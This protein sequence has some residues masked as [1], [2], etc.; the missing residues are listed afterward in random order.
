MAR[1]PNLFTTGVASLR[2][3][4]LPA[5]RVPPGRR[6]ISSARIPDRVA[7]SRQAAL[8]TGTF[9]AAALRPAQTT[10]SFALQ[11][12]RT[13]HSASGFVISDLTDSEYHDI[14]RDT[15]ETLHDNLEVL[16]EETDLP[17]FDVEYTSGVMTLCLGSHG[18]YVV[19]KQP[20]N[21]QIWLSSPTSGPKRFDYDR[22]SGR[23]FYHRDS[24]TL[25][26]LL[27]TELSAIVGDAVKVL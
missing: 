10:C 3:H 5:D 21:K 24:S 8:V 26:G 9:G 2:R 25:D 4:L 15:M 19:N 7:I 17:G 11:P 22:G 20:P 1:L 6:L 18:T 12:R 13:T 23:W 14:S 16:C 27:N